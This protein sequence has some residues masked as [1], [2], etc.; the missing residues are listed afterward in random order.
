MLRKTLTSILTTFTVFTLALSPALAQSTVDDPIG[1]QPQL[2][3]TQ[4]TEQESTPNQDVT[5][6][7]I[8]DAQN[9]DLSDPFEI[10]LSVGRQSAWTGRVPITITF[11]PKIDS[12]RTAIEWD[13]PPAL[14]LEQDYENYFP[15]T[16]GVA[17]SREVSIDPSSPGRFTITANI[18]DWGYGRNVSSS[19]NITIVI[20][21]DLLISPQDPNYMLFVG[22]KYL[23]YTVGLIILLAASAVAVKIT[24]RRLKVWLEPPV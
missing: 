16:Q 8:V 12:T 2:N 17:Y 21:D 23:V 1:P 3:P 4:Q 10:T 19:E 5:D 18:I 14:N 11:V 24:L 7:D 6:S 9:P 13:A 20:D 22:A 15:A